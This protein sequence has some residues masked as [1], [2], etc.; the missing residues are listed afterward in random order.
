MV[1]RFL[2]DVRFYLWLRMPR[3]SETP[4]LCHGMANVDSNGEFDCVTSYK[5]GDGLVPGTHKV[6]I[7]AAN[8]R[9]GK[10]VVPKEYT[11]C[12][13]DAPGDR[14][15][16]PSARDQSAEA[17]RESVT[18]DSPFQDLVLRCRLYLS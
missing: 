8:E 1:R 7:Q 11:E 17:Q 3:R 16:Q 2:A 10:P 9:D 15:G 4:I 18:D 6:V 12:G 14:Y 5:Y 13:D